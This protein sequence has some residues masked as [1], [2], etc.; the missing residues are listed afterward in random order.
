M[1]GMSDEIIEKHHAIDVI[2]NNAGVLRADEVCTAEGLELRFAVNSIAPFLITERLLALMP[3]GGRVVNLSSAAQAALNP[4][5]LTQCEP[6][7]DMAAYS[8]S[9]LAITAWTRRMADFHS[10]KVFVA[11]NPASLLGTKMVKEGF[12]IDGSDISVGADIIC[13]A[14]ISDEFASASGLYYDNDAKSFAPPHH[15]ARD[16]ALADEIIATMRAICASVLNQE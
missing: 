9:K 3:K 5:N 16:D 14:A 11:V 2:I 7:S 15:D 1:S 13:R 12:G 6:M 8:Q 4:Q 10:D